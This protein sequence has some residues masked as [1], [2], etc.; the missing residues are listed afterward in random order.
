M[1]D[2]DYVDDIALLI[3]LSTQN[4]FCIA[5]NKQRQVLTITQTTIK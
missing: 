1:T 4:P 5:K 3:K 2:A